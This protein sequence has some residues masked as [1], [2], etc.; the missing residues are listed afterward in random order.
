[1]RR[2]AVRGWTEY[3]AARVAL[4]GCW[5]FLR[6][7]ERFPVV[8]RKRARRLPLVAFLMRTSEVCA[9]EWRLARPMCKVL[10]VTAAA[11][12]ASARR[13]EFTTE[14]KLEVLDPEIAV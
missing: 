4:L 8:L 3:E 9:D 6:V 1:M 2:L 12:A 14:T 5:W 7:S 10:P 11:C 13:L